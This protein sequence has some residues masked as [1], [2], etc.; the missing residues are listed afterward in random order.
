MFI[1]NQKPHRFFLCI[2]FMKKADSLGRYYTYH[3]DY[4]DYCTNSYATEDVKNHLDS[5]LTITDAPGIYI[6][7]A[8]LAS[9]CIS[10]FSC[11]PLN[12]I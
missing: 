5:L 4:Y 2:S 10:Y 3:Q 7:H 1:F 11:T 12:K 9:S 6:L 8:F